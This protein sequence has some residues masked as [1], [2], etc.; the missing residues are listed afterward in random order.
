MARKPRMEFEGAFYH[1]IA[2]GNP[3]R[4]ILSNDRDR[5]A[6]LGGAS[7]DTA[8]AT[9]SSST[10]RFR[11]GRGRTTPTSRNFGKSR[12]FKVC[13]LVLEL[14]CCQI[15]LCKLHSI[16]FGF[17]TLRRCSGQVLDFGLGPNHRSNLRNQFTM[18]RPPFFA[19]HLLNKIQI[20]NCHCF[21]PR[22]VSHRQLIPES[23]R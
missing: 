8:S 15:G 10:V 16:N 7:S 20:A 4:S 2:R 19:L 21:R 6:Y 13:F 12:P 18:R 5:E 23:D 3:R 14:L 1:V 17:S 9:I 22:C 11:R